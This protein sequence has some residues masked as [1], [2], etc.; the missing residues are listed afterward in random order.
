[1]AAV[2]NIILNSIFIHLYGYVAAAYTTVTCYVL[3]YCIHVLLA[4]KIHGSVIY[5][6]SWHI[7]CPVG[8]TAFSFLCL[9]LLGLPVLR[10]GMVVVILGAA[11]M[12][13]YRKLSELNGLMTN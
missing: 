9:G 6:M 10:W 12:I 11:G 8:G 1:M 5:S 13:G 7:L 4:R 2:L 3:Y